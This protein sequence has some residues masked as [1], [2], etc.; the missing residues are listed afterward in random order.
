MEQHLTL[1]LGLTKFMVPV[2]IPNFIFSL[3]KIFHQTMVFIKFSID[4]FALY[5]QLA[6][7]EDDVA[8]HVE[9][10]LKKNEKHLRLKGL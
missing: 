3:S 10:N 7:T 5:C 1:L 8:C 2:N 9:D 4:N 6:L